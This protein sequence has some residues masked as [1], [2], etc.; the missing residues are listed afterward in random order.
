MTRYILAPEALQDLQELWNYIA[1]ENLD[2][3]DRM[4]DTLFAAF[5]RLAAMPGLGH[6]R[7]DLTDRPLRFW[8]VDAYLVIYRAERTPIE[9]V[10]VTRGGTG[11]PAAPPAPLATAC[12]SVWGCPRGLGAFGADNLPTLA[13]LR[14]EDPYAILICEA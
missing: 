11:H 8:T 6:R 13:S 4:I 10:A 9:I 2:A 3:A 14:I 7:E 1:T 5:E 12:S